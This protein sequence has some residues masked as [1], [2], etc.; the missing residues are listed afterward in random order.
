MEFISSSFLVFE[1]YLKQQKK[2]LMYQ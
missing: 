2:V 1:F